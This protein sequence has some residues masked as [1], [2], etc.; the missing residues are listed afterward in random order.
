MTI[1]YNVKTFNVLKIDVKTL[2][3]LNYVLWIHAY[4]NVIFAKKNIVHIL[5]LLLL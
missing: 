2:T 4:F 5:L 1:V 3:H